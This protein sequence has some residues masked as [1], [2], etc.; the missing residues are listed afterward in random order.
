MNAKSCRMLALL[1]LSSCD[2]VNDQFLAIEPIELD[3]YVTFKQAD[4][5]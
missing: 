3:I 1:V 4:T 5:L 2:K